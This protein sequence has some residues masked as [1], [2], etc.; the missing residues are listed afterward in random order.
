[1]VDRYKVREWVGQ[2]LEEA[3]V[4]YWDYMSALALKTPEEEEADE[5][6]EEDLEELEDEDEEKDKG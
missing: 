6:S 4:A 3:R 2:R 5:A 1:M